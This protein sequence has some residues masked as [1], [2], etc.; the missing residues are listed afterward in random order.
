MPLWLG[1]QSEL[2]T[3]FFKI[4]TA[5]FKVAAVAGDN[6][7]GIKAV[8]E[9][10]NAIVYMSIGEADIA[11]GQGM[12]IKSLTMHGITATSRNVR[13]GQFPIQ[14]PLMLVTRNLPSG[15]MK[16]FID[17]TLSPN[18]T[19]IILECGFVPYLD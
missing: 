3:Q 15:L 14:R 12:P 5:D 1:A 2:F 8:V 16:A 13:N 4:K 17:F 18:A 19:G 9:N 6:Q 11:A 10:P 7:E